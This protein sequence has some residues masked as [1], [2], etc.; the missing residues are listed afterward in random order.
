MTTY[1]Q[2][3]QILF[4]NGT[5]HVDETFIGGKRKYNRSRIPNV[6]PRYLF[7]I[8]DNQKIFLQF[9]ER[10]DFINIIPLITR[11]VSP[12]VTINTDGAKV[13][14]TLDSMNYTHKT[15][16][17]KEHFVNPI[18]GTHS[19]WIENI[20]GNLKIK[21]KSLRGSQRRMLDRHLDEYVY[22][23]NRKEGDIFNLIL[24]NI[25][26]FYPV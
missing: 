5:V 21:L 19:N 22:R 11:H 2:N 7:G 4:A 15:C 6:N 3:N 14:K 26:S 20:W 25:A 1:I 17:H 8:T 10:R 23:Y 16:I 12:G 18:D 9:V 13:Y 24:H